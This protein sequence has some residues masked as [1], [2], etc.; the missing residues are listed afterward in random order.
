[1]VIVSGLVLLFCFDQQMTENFQ[2]FFS[3]DHFQTKVIQFIQNSQT[4]HFNSYNNSRSL[5]FTKK[6]SIEF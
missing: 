1:M 6:F 4:S 2:D 3:K 5:N